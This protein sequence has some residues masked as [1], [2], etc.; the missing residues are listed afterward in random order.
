M[1]YKAQIYINRSSTIMN[2]YE[3]KYK[4]NIREYSPVNM[5]NLYLQTL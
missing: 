4:Y 5:I 1:I 3:A 2:L